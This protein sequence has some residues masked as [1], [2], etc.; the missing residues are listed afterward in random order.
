MSVLWSA[1]QVPRIERLGR[2]KQVKTCI[3]RFINIGVQEK[4]IGVQEKLLC[5][6]NMEDGRSS[7]VSTSE[8]IGLIPILRVQTEHYHLR[9]SGGLVN[10]PEVPARSLRPDSEE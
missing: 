9:I 3:S 8:G 4:N 6:F 2:V 5:A 10:N 7:S 1:N